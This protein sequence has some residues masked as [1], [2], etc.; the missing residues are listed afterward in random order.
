MESKLVLALWDLE[1]TANSTSE[2]FVD[3]VVPRH[4]R[5]GIER[6]INVDRMPTTFTEKLTSVLFQV[7]EQ[8]TPSHAARLNASR[9]TGLP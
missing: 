6:G 3:L 4:R 7:P 5:Y 1:I 9:V 2:E 8:V